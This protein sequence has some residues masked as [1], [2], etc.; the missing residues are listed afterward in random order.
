MAGR[1]I[2]LLILCGLLAH[3]ARAQDSNPVQDSAV[4]AA[5]DTAINARIGQWNRYTAR[6]SSSSL[7]LHTDKSIYVPNSYLLFTGYLFKGDH[8]T[9]RHHTLYVALVDP[10]RKKTVASDRFVMRDIVGSGAL[11]LP[12]T[13]PPGSYLLVAYTNVLLEGQVQKPFRRLIHI[14]VP[15]ER[16][17]SLSVSAA[18]L[19][20]APG[21]PP[22]SRGA[23]PTPV[24]TDSLHIKCRVTTSYGGLAA[25]ATFTYTLTTEGRTL[26]SGTKKID[27]FGEVHLSVPAADSL[28]TGVILTAEVKRDTLSEDFWMPVSVERRGWSI[29]Y[30]PEGGNLV[31]G[32][33]SRI[34]VD[35]RN[36]AGMGVSAQG[37]LLEDGRPVGSFKTGDY[38]LGLLDCTPDKAKKYTVQLT[39]V[40]VGTELSGDFPEIQPAGYTMSIPDAVVRDSLTVH[41]LAPQTG[42]SCLLMVYNDQDILYA[43][44]LRLRSDEGLIRIPAD[45]L[46]KGLAT[47]TLFDDDGL[48]VAERA[49]YFPGQKLTVSIQSDSAE[50]H[51]GSRVTLHVKVTDGQGRGIQSIFSLASVLA[52]R[53]TPQTDPDIVSYESFGRYISDNHCFVTG[54]DHFDAVSPTA[55]TDS[56]IDLTLLTRFWTRYRWTEIAADTVGLRLVSHPADYGY[57]LYKDK[58]PKGPVQ[59]L[60]MGSG[61]ASYQ[62]V[63]TDS[64]GHFQ[65]APSMLIA[66]QASHTLLSVVDAGNQDRYTLRVL[67][68]YD[69][70]N[71][72]LARSW[73]YPLS[74]GRG[75]FNGREETSPEEPVNDAE[76]NSVKTLKTIL[77]K[78]GGDHYWGD[79]T[80]NDYVCP[81]NVLNCP[82]HPYGRRPVIGET[83]MYFDSYGAPPRQVV[84]S[85]CVSPKTVSSF[86]NEVRTIH[87]T[88]EFYQPDKNGSN[89]PGL[90]TLVNSTLFWSPLSVTGKNGEATLSFYTQQLS[91]RFYNII[92]GI[93]GLG[94][95]SGRS[96]FTIRPSP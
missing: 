58:P 79:A 43:S 66:P 11:F 29:H 84:Y 77:I 51:T 54:V 13:L 86:L 40:P 60:L 96:A 78:A 83:Y 14:R 4:N 37:F 33:A 62:T 67:N 87:L 10:S 55:G 42:S 74:D 35:I 5:L 20:V 24:A 71:H 45:S 1:C 63:T 53:M 8:D 90:E 46:L 32:H 28:L 57:V 38:G 30:Y 93:S 91:G 76:F 92:Q 9:A 34:G 26:Q 81:Y 69:A 48:P 52:A 68:D 18:E 7:Y 16:P 41:I 15:Q 85:G 21:S 6:H 47:V 31:S 2:L 59:L 89:A 19:P 65:L 82:N 36:A 73:Y 64:N 17:F 50:Y 75:P 22:V 56:L 72:A 70:V 23:G 12:D 39:D 95:I 25:G 49:I 88:K 94:A 27:P 3:P 80:C 61:A 44:A